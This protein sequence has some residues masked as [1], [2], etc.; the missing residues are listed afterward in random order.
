MLYGLLY[1]YD[2]QISV[3]FH[4]DNERPVI[5]IRFPRHIITVNNDPGLPSANV[6]WEAIN[7]TD[8]SGVVNISSNYH[9]GESFQIGDTDVAYT[10]SDPSGNMQSAKFRVTVKG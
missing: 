10:A 9:S 6:T 7:V 4:T 1:P 5:Q 3:Y 8:N 2:T